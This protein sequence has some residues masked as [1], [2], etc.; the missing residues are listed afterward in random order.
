VS[1]RDDIDLD[2]E[3]RAATK[4]IDWKAY[5]WL[6]K[7][8][9]PGHALVKVDGGYFRVGFL[10][11]RGREG[12]WTPAADR[13]QRAFIMQANERASAIDDLVAWRPNSPQSFWRR[14]GAATLLGEA[15]L[16]E[17][18]DTD[19]PARLFANPYEFLRGGRAGFVIL[20]WTA[21]LPMFVD[22]VPAFL[23]DDMALYGRLTRVLE[24]PRR[25]PPILI[26]RA[27]APGAAAI[28]QNQRS[29][30]A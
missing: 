19:Q 14:S 12:M 5:H 25:V 11:V 16:F 24:R 21:R 8:G 18:I 17:A 28:S 1:E 13:G 6:T 20:D 22:Q 2:A 3:W 30:A 15:A 27:A 9:V 23:V 4:D 26:N 7:K 10:K 29:D